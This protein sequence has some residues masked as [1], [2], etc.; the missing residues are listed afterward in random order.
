MT[1]L[2]D[3]TGVC[4]SGR[5]HHSQ[6]LVPLMDYL[7]TQGGINIR[8]VTSAFNSFNLDSFERP[9]KDQGLQYDLIQDWMTEELV[10]EMHR[11]NRTAQNQITQRM[12]LEEHNILDDI[13]TIWV[14]D[15]FRDTLECYVLFRQYLKDVRPDIVFVLHESNF[16]TKILA[17]WAKELNIPVVSF[18][19]GMYRP[20]GDS[21]YF[22]TLY[23]KILAQY[24][25]RVCLW[26]N[27][28]K[29]IF[30]DC[31]VPAEKLVPVGAAHLDEP[32]AVPD[33]VRQN[34]RH[35]LRQDLQIKPNQQLILM[36]LSP[37]KIWQGNLTRDIRLVSQ[38]VRENPGKSLIVKWHPMEHSE[39]VT[40]VRNQLEPGMPTLPQNSGHVIHLHER[41][42]L[43][44]IWASDLALIQNSTTGLE[45]L[46]FGLPLVEWN[47]EPNP[48]PHSYFADGVAERIHHAEDIPRLSNFLN[49]EHFEVKPEA[50][51]HYIE[52]MLYRLDGNARARI[53]DLVATIIT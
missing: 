24:S 27:Y 46:A 39:L 22:R 51:E 48:L 10:Q 35:K 49:G 29:D 11:L 21:Q 19:E 4:F 34:I 9:L 26:G 20:P 14:R 6:K 12:F 42:I 3:K 47:L 43:H 7:H 23:G 15:A 16:W 32:L 25:T 2:N 30:L 36:L 1:H 31:G 18:Q 40:Q 50:V 45:C 33:H 53:L 52:N 41:D 17:Y 5:V 13:S 37:S 8:Y 28:A 44:L 38:Y